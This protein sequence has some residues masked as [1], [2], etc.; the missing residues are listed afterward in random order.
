MAGPSSDATAEIR[1]P[2]EFGADSDGPR[3]DGPDFGDEPDS[4]TMAAGDEANVPGSDIDA[5]FDF[6][7]PQ[8]PFENLAALP[9]DLQEAFEAFKLAILH[10]KLSQWQEVASADVV[11][12]LRALEAMAL[13]P[14]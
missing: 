4:S 5:P 13:A 14:A 12:A 9:A 1:D 6:P 2:R 11:A 3:H 8:R 10:H 7:T